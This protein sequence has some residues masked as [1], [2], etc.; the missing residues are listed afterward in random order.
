MEEIL[1]NYN[2]IYKKKHM[3]KTALKITFFILSNIIFLLLW[4][5]WAVTLNKKAEW[6]E[7]WYV[8]PNYSVRICNNTSIDF[9]DLKV[10]WNNGPYFMEITAGNCSKYTEVY[11]LWTRQ[12][13]SI[14][15]KEDNI[16]NRYLY[17]LLD[18][19]DLQAA[20]LWKYTLNIDELN[21][22]A[23]TIEHQDGIKYELIKDWDF[24]NPYEF[25]TLK[26]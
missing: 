11:E 7:K 10:I 2:L 3:K 1:F 19:M 6:N 17:T 21:H 18:T 23:V 22:W 8:L 26:L 12:A 20:S 4:Y 16:R 13:I 9:E 5:F 15:T 14:T 25:L 24:K